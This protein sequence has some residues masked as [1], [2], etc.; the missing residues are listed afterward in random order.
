MI[1]GDKDPLGRTVLK[2]RG[3]LDFQKVYASIKDWFNA[4]D[5][6]INEKDYT[7][8]VRGHGDEYKMNIIGDKDIN[9]YVNFHID[10]MI[11][12]PEIKKDSGNMRMSIEPSLDLDYRGYFNKNS[13]T[14]F[15]KYVY[16]N[17][18]IYKKIK[19]YYEAKV[20]VEYLDLCTKIKEAMNQYD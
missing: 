10:I 15:L 18:I 2:Q 14:R 1:K 13:F 3:N 8:T 16:N 17:Y 6:D 12:A 4:H 11:F 19:T 5:Y 9:S 20:Y 7:H